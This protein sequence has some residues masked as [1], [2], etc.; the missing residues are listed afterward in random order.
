MVAGRNTTPQNRFCKDEL[1]P[2]FQQI[3]IWYISNIRIMLM[4]VNMISRLLLLFQ[5]ERRKTY[6]SSLEDQKMKLLL[7]ILNLPL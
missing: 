6:C 1:G 2:K 4:M 3:R 7:L 5:R